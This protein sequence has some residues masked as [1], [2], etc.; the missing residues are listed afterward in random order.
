MQDLMKLWINVLEISMINTI[1]DSSM[2]FEKVPKGGK[3]FV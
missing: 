2:L 1:V 3:D